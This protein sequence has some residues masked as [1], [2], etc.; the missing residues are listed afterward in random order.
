MLSFDSSYL[1]NIRNR[2]KNEV[3]LT[4]LVLIQVKLANACTRI[5]FEAIEICL[6][7]SCLKKL[8]RNVLYMFRI[9][10]CLIY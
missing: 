8:F 6:V 9:K 4:C 5:E 1:A 7:H 10:L 2:I 3:S